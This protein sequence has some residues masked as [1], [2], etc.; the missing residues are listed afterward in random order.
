LG[1]A[2]VGLISEIF[3]LLRFKVALLI[4]FSELLSKDFAGRGLCM[5]MEGFPFSVVN[6]FNTPSSLAPLQ[7]N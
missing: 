1:F 6:R 3:E 4:R 5:Q 2:A 7:H